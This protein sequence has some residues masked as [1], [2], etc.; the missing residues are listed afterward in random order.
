[1]NILVT[2]ASGYVGRSF[3]QSYQ[4]RHHF[5]T[6]S[7]QSM[8]LEDLDLHGTDAIVHAAAL[9]HQ[10]EP[11]PDEAYHQ[12]NVLY[13][14]ELAKRAKANGVKQ[15]IFIS[16][17]AIYG[18]S[19]HKITAQSIPAPTTPYGKS[20][21]QA[22]LA[23]Q[24]LE[25]KSFNVVIIRPPMIYGAQ[26]P[27]NIHA[28]TRLIQKVPIL[29]FGGIKNRRSFL[30]IG[31][32][33]AFIEHTLST[34]SSGSFLIADDEAVST[35]YLIQSLTRAMN[36]SCWLFRPPLF[37]RLL[38]RLRPKIHSRLYEDLTVDTSKTK[39]QLQ[40]H[41][42]YSFDRAILKSFS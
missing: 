42:P 27:G 17:I 33:T 12:A 32:L 20:K 38:K 11:L 13:P 22:E 4:N 28:L 19:Y 41:P 10:K 31:N 3:I 29:P 14:L 34:Q 18:E 30:Y 35:T 24:A 21:L 36:R 40:F 25:D 2:G 37:E 8:Q 16:S 15:F 6:F 1:M 26:A 7:N 9:V 23:L 39:E 5:S